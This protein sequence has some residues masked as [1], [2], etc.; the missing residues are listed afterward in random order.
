MFQF[1]ELKLAYCSA[2]TVDFQLHVGGVPKLGDHRTKKLGSKRQGARS[3]AEL[4]VL[5]RP[6]NSSF[7]FPMD[8]DIESLVHLEQSYAAA[9]W[10]VSCP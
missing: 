1:N 2:S 6:T 7:P 10:K 9:V 8:V 4:I 3:I 5:F